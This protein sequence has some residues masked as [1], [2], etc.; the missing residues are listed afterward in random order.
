MGILNCEQVYDRRTYGLDQEPGLYGYS[1]RRIP[2]GSMVS[3]YVNSYRKRHNRQEQDCC[4]IPEDF[5]DDF[6]R[7]SRMLS[8]GNEAVP[9][10]T[11]Q[12]LGAISAR[13]L[14]AEDIANDGFKVVN[15]ILST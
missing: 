15:D 2:V 5:L 8:N 12:L 10:P 11:A 13:R 14:G 3:L 4:Y 6:K 9:I 1:G 7:E